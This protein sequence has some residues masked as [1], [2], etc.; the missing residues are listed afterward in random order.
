MA[1]S[2]LNVAP[3]LASLH[4]ADGRTVA[5]GLLDTVFTDSALLFQTPGKLLSIMSFWDELPVGFPLLGFSFQTPDA[6]TFCKYTYG[7][8][9]YLN[10][11]I[12]AN[13]F[14]K[15]PG[16]IEVIGLRPIQRGNP[17]IANYIANKLG[18]KYIIEKYADAGGLWAIN[19]LW[20]YFDNLVLTELSGTKVDGSE[21]GGIGFKFTFKRMNFAALG[22][23]GIS[24]NSV[25][26]AIA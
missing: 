4:G 5:Y 6:L 11:A 3:S 19:T 25:V 18:I 16:D 8:Y 21:L 26:A 15:E 12:I 13:S 7:E 23:K 9:P 22:D 17:L 2:I 24:V 14:Y 1:I 20:G 10:K